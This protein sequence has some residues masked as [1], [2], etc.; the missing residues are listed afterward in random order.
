MKKKSPLPPG[1]PKGYEPASKSYK[2]VTEESFY[3]SLPKSP[4]SK[5]RNAKP[6]K[7]KPL[8]VTVTNVGK[9]GKLTKPPKT[10]PSS[11]RRKK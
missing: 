6:V 4:T 1:V 9:G 5:G 3:P 2:L 11:K 10:R 8:E 7:L